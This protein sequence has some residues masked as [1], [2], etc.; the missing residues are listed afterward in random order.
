[1]TAS[2]RASDSSRTAALWRWKAAGVRELADSSALE[3]EIEVVNRAQR[4]IASPQQT[5]TGRRWVSL[6]KISTGHHWVELLMRMIL[7][8]L[9][10]LKRTSSLEGCQRNVTC[11]RLP[12][13]STTGSH[14]IHTTTA[15]TDTWQC[16]ESLHDL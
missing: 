10:R 6:W 2:S 13:I 4:R 7:R 3:V 14:F 9:I 1:M 5:S 16:V 8:P 15:P 11:P 12:C